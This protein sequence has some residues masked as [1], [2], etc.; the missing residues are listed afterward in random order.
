MPWSAENPKYRLRL[1]ESHHR[2]FDES[3]VRRGMKY[4]GNACKAGM[5]VLTL[6]L[7]LPVLAQTGG[8][9]RCPA[10]GAADRARRKLPTGAAQ[11]AANS[12]NPAASPNPE[13]SA[14][15]APAP[16]DTLAP[17]DAPPRA[18]LPSTAIPRDLSPWSMFLGADILVKAVMIGLAL[19]SLVTWTI[20]SGQ[21]HR[22]PH[23][24]PSP[25]DRAETHRARGELVASPFAA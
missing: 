23:R 17:N 20:L 8:G 25:E 19:A 12:P 10:G 11:S 1:I 21:D 7:A 24:A 22:A 9:L 16:A 2:A 5:L 13:A 14:S 3:V 15:A 18:I 6:G 4:I